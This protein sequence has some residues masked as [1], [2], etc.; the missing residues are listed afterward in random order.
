[1]SRTRRA[2]R[3]NSATSSGARPNSFTSCAP[4]TLNRSVI[5]LFIS[6]LTVIWSRAIRCSRL[7][8]RLAGITKIGRTTSASSVSRHSSAIIAASVVTRTTMLLTTLPS[9]RRDGGLRTDHVVVEAADQ[10]AGLRA[11]EEGD[12]HPLDLVEQRDA[13]VVDQALTDARAAPPLQDREPG[14][15][16]GG[17]DDDDGEDGDQPPV[18]FGDRGV[19]DRAEGE[20]GHEPDERGREDRPEEPDDGA[21]VRPSEARGAADRAPLELGPAQ[22]LGVARVHPVGH[23]A[24]EDTVGRRRPAPS[25]SA[26]ARQTAW[27]RFARRVRA[28]RARQTA[29]ARFARRVRARPTLG[30]SRRRRTK[31]SPRDRQG[32]RLRSRRPASDP[33]LYTRRDAPT[34]S[35]RCPRRGPGPRRCIVRERRQPA[36]DRVQRRFAHAPR[37]HGPGHR[38]AVDHGFRHDR[39]EQHGPE[40]HGSCGHGTGRHRPTGRHRRT[41]GHRPSRARRQHAR[42]DGRGVRLGGG[43]P[44]RRGRLAR[45]TDR[46]RRSL[47]GIVRAPRLPPPRRSRRADRQPARQPRRPRVRRIR[48]G[49][50][51]RADLQRRPA[52]AVRHRRVGSTRH[53]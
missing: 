22:H 27:A 16:E 49:A 39:T 9:V 8:T 11:R 7:P 15:G 5:W 45:G 50:L 41:G 29:W 42:S 23:H 26:P 21:P 36:G 30:A 52:R 18:A 12:R 51:R 24:S 53:R 25:V 31:R 28:L 10:R 1:M 17:G 48:V 47:A 38:R 2:R 32:D 14:L 43:P 19:E 20:R 33:H 44:R 34:P 35:R 4:A 37:R 3:S 6:A 40:H 46:L 13:Q